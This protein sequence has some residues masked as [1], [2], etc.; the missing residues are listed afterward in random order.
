MRGAAIDWRRMAGRAVTAAVLALLA[1]AISPQGLTHL[2]SRSDLTFRVT[3]TSVCL[4]AFLSLLAVAAVATGRVRKLIFYLI[5]FALP[6]ALL[7]CLE[8]TAIAVDLADRVSPLEDKS[9]F[10]TAGSWP[11]HLMS[12]ARFH[13][14]PGLRLYMPWRG[15]GIAINELG[16]RTDAPR[17][18]QPGEWRIAI[19]GGS[20]MWGTYVRD[21]DTIP[22]QVA[23]VLRAHGHGNIAVY[24]FGIEGARLAN[25]LAL[26]ER[27]R[28]TYALDQV[29]FYTGANDVFA[30]YDD[31]QP[32]ANSWTGFTS[33]ELVKAANRLA[34]M[35][36]T[37]GPAFEAE[38][39]DHVRRSNKLVSTMAAAAAYCDEVKL[40]CDFALQPW[41][42]S[43][44]HPLGSE[45]RLRTSI[46]ANL[47]ALAQ[48][49]DA[50]YAGALAA[51]P[52][53]YTFD[54]RG[55]LDA[56]GSPVFAD[57][58]HVNEV[59]NAAIAQRLEAIIA[60]RFP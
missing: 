56:V 6:A 49:W 27:F 30:A 2:S 18:K 4:S 28:E 23:R 11:S 19:T 35:L 42:L 22:M 34:A 57:V 60:R 38:S 45:T 58:I 51:G 46:D 52:K 39:R 40:K 31:W 5:A 3:F 29:L 9:V 8:A 47:P 36:R 33:L 59:G 15:D 50:M 55:A 37:G 20:T 54:L 43:R 1:L 14:E 7:A 53:D 41:L 48:L 24:N 25:E 16:L 44:A 26:L 17:P 32:P 12:Q 10:A 21:V 13:D